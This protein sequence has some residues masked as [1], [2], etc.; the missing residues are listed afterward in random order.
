MRGKLGGLV[1]VTVLMCSGLM[2]ALPA[3]AHAD[4]MLDVPAFAQTNYPGPLGGGN[5]NDFVPSG[6]GVTS[7][8]MV[9]KYY[10]VSTD[11]RQLNTALV[12]NN[13]FSGE[14]LYWSASSISGASGGR[15]SLAQ[16]TTSVSWPSSTGSA[17]R[18]S[19]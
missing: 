4:V 9:F 3:L 11:P 19:V 15:V 18:A 1:T 17:L 8:A 6:C 2:L 7:M 13:G 10:G 14:L 16:N 5:N 12:A